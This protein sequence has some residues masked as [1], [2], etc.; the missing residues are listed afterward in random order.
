MHIVR[1]LTPFMNT[2]ASDEG[3]DDDVG[4]AIGERVTVVDDLVLGP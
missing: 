3:S 1:Q 4:I 2:E